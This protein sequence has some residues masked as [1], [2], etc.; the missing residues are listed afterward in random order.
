MNRVGPSYDNSAINSN[1]QL[2]DL[3]FKT[4]FISIEGH[5]IHYIDEG[6]HQARPILLLHGVPTWS[7]LFR[8]I[9]PEL[10]A[11]NHRVIAPDLLGFGRSS[12]PTDKEFYTFDNLTFLL[13]LFIEKLDL[14][15]IIL[16][17]HD[18]GAIFGLRLAI[19]NKNRFSGLAICNGYLPRGDEEVHPLFNIWK[20]VTKY[21]PFLPVSRFINM[22]CNKKL[23]KIEKL[24]YDLPFKGSAKKLAI[25]I[26]P[27][28]L[29]FKYGPNKDTAK[30]IW[31]G[32]EKWEKP[33]ITLFSKNDHITRGGD[34]IIQTHVPGA[35][36]Q[37]HQR[38]EG[39]HFSPEDSPAEISKAINIF[40]STI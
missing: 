8:N 13:K 20:F 32:L 5:S 18:W 9:I 25:K 29:P 36:N 1:I 14:N 2:P 38:I 15:Q 10:L 30:T 34:K 33:I 6:L 27:Q 39:G 19:E 31:E 23:T 40:I 3:P 37:K 26:L 35:I 17:G 11:A 4:N 16:F 28:L 7:Y 12:K 22:G 21:S 24:A